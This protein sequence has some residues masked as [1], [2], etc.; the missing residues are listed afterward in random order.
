VYRRF[1]D[2]DEFVEAV[3]ALGRRIK[4]NALQRELFPAEA[5]A[6]AEATPAA[7]A[8]APKKNHGRV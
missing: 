3:Q 5:A 4:P 6:E 1:E 8:V 2:P 7:K